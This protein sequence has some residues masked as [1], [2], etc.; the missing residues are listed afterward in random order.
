MQQ[1]ELWREIES[2]PP[3]ARREVIDFITFRRMR[4][5]LPFIG[6]T[7]KGKLTDEPFVGMWRDRN[8]MKDSKMWVRNIREREWEGH[9]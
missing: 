1:D 8:D 9:E 5:K 6:M 2:L 4:Y 7:R 3:E